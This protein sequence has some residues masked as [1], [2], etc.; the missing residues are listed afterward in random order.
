MKPKK[1]HKSKIQSFGYKVEISRYCD[2]SEHSDE[3]YGPWSESYSN[4]FISIKKTEQFG[5]VFSSLDL[6]KTAGFLVWVEYSTGDSFGHAERG[7]VEVVAICKTQKG[8]KKLKEFI[9]SVSAEDSSEYRQKITIDGQ[10]LEIYCPW[11][12]F[13]DHLDEVHIQPVGSI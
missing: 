7:Q 8:A 11:L 10:K 12:G 5:D 9:H 3:E 6:D 2:F 4:S 1:K 13:F